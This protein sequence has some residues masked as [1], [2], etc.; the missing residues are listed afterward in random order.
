MI[1]SSVFD[2]VK[3]QYGSMASWAVWAEVGAKAK[4]HMDDLT[5]LDPAENP[6]LLR[7]LHTNFVLLGLNIS[8]RIKCSLG[9]FHVDKPTGPAYKIRYALKNTPLW[10]AYMTDVIK[11]FEEPIS[12]NMLAYLRKHPDFE[13][14]NMQQLRDE[15]AVVGATKPVLVTFG[16]IAHT[17]VQRHF[18]NEF[19]ILP[20]PHYAEQSSQ[21][22][23][24]D[25]VLVCLQKNGYM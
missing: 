14:T 19:K 20:L 21:Q 11:N 6:E 10:G 7:V 2:A 22:I 9:N 8:H 5:V 4:S 3:R 12:E 23:Y 15:L 1:S 18:V 17:I 24:R 25:K 13:R 16:T